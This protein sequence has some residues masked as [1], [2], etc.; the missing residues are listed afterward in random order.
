MGFPRHRAV[1]TDPCPAQGIEAESPDDD[2]REEE[3]L[4]RK[5]RPP[6]R[7]GGAPKCAAGNPA[8]SV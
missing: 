5:A 8:V 7:A 1:T 3:D 4:Q 2:R 6:R